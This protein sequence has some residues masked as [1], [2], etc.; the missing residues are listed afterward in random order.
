MDEMPPP[1]LSAGRVAGID[2]GRRR[3]GVAICDAEW[4]LASPLCVHETT[5]DRE[6][7]ARFFSRLAREQGIAGFIVG[8]PLHADGTAGLMATEARHFGTWLGRITG[9]PVAFPDELFTPHAAAGRLA[10]VGLSRQRRKAR[11]D[12][13]AAQVILATWLDA[14]RSTAAPARPE[15]PA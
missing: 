6:A 11:V 12:A 4:I 9:L 3:I 1:S 8:L 2:Y 14:A 10:G 15:P 13:V 5:G 7:D